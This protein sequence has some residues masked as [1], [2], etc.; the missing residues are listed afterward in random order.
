MNIILRKYEYTKE[1]TGGPIKSYDSN[2]LPSNAPIEDTAN[3]AIC[4]FSKGYMFGV[5]DGHGGRY[6]AQVIAKRLMRYIA[7]QLANSA[8]LKTNLENKIPSHEYLTYFND[9]VCTISITPHYPIYKLNYYVI[10]K[11]TINF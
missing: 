6:C 5:F 4:Q 9:Q 3:E 11:P 1:L 2:Q 7:A 10:I 8:T